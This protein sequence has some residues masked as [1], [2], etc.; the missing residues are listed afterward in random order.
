MRNL[1]GRLNARPSEDLRRIATF[2]QASSSG[3]DRARQIGAL[4][5]GMTDPRAVRDAWDHLS[6]DEQN[7]VR[8]L[9]LRE[10]GVLTI[11]EIADHLGIN[12]SAARET[13]AALYRVGILSREGDDDPL[14]VGAVPRLFLPRELA[15]L[16]RRIQ[17]EIEAGDLSGT[18]LR[19]LLE[20]LDDA[21]LEEAAEI[22]GIQVIPGLRER[23][24]LGRQVLHQIGDPAR[25]EAVAA[26][27]RRDAL[28]LWTRVRDEPGG[29]PVALAAAAESVGLGS[30]A[31]SSANRLREALADLETALLVWHTYRPDGS[32][33][34][35]V[36]AEIRAP[37]PPEQSLPPL[38]PLVT[39]TVDA[40]SWR[41]PHA[42]AWDLLTVLR[43]LVTPG[44]PHG[45]RAAALPR[46]W[47]QVLNHRLW[48]P[49]DDVPPLDYLD[50]L[51]D[52]AL[53]EGLLHRRDEPD[54]PQLDVTGKIRAW[55]D[56][57]FPEQT[58]RLR[59]SW[60]KSRDWIEGRGRADIEVWGA[61]WRGFRRR[62]LPHL[63]ELDPAAWYPVESVAAWVAAREPD[64]LG[65]TFTAATARHTGRRDEP[66][67][68]RRQ[69]AVAEA[70][71]VAIET[72]LNWFGIVELA[73]AP[74][75]I[76]AL[77]APSA[78]HV[79]N[80]EVEEAVPAPG[81]PGAPPLSVTSD[82]EI[83]LRHPTPLR[84]WSLSAFAD[85]AQLAEVSVYRITAETLG[86]ALQAGFDLAQVTGFL[87]KQ[88][89][90][91]LPPDLGTRL[92]AWARRYGRVR[93]RRAIILEPDDEGVLA[94]LQQ[95]AVATGL[96]V[97]QIE[98]HQLLV[99]LPP[100]PADAEQ[101]RA[102]DP[103]GVLLARLRSRGYTPQWVKAPAPR[104]PSDAPTG[105]TP[106][107]ESATAR[108][109]AAR[110]G[111]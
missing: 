28:R 48:N 37:A 61:D 20:L 102:Q 6:S 97:H 110:E 26:K 58:D 99:E 90:G 42:L 88:T 10:D 52:L 100:Q 22:W 43:G 39:L 31:P 34:L 3:T 83:Q 67:T 69:A 87:A 82:G 101:D 5:R 75:G 18:P 1:L 93:L 59:E 96:T 94:D 36:P 23:E 80:L 63:T 50:F 32:R 86:R 44:A 78:A 25:V 92:D 24:D 57:S 47:L 55:R 76:R 111:A 19:A 66:D 89:G 71:R 4:Y 7:I 84:V 12:E 45:D 108:S 81:V 49:G 77:Q 8:L 29:A 79:G 2:W 51:L 65:A 68:E 95:A 54:G 40:P 27:R 105:S 13:A 109:S 11:S 38:T 107:P 17:D 74:G 103:E 30:D 56:R 46:A 9:A 91:G 62:L 35:F 106:D 16:F 41:H 98:D 73:D 64:L 14:P 15:L 104:S 53:A 70:V 85:P 72:S 33:W 21:E 60:L